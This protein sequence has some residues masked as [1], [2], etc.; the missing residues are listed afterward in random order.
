[1][2]VT[3]FHWRCVTGTFGCHGEK[4]HCPDSIPIAF[5]HLFYINF[6]IPF[7]PPMYSYGLLRCALVL[8]GIRPT[9]SFGTKQ[10]DSTSRPKNIYGMLFSRS[11]TA[12]PP[13][14]EMCTKRML[15]ARSLLLTSVW[16]STE[17]VVTKELS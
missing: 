9:E 15:Q 5:V 7:K 3:K 14:F 11:H 10:F 13:C 17:K 12:V 4:K 6:R 1:M 2:P 16:D 8:V